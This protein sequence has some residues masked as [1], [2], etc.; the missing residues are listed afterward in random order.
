MITGKN[1]TGFWLLLM[2]SLSFAEGPKDTSRSSLPS[3]DM[4]PTGSVLTHVEIPRYDDQLRAKSLLEAEKLTVVSEDT[5]HGDIVKI[6]LLRPDGT[7][8][9]DADFVQADYKHT[10]GLLTSNDKTILR[11]DRFYATGQGVVTDWQNQQGLLLGPVTTQLI[12]NNPT[13]KMNPFSPPTRPSLLASLTGILLTAQLSAD[14]NEL[15]SE[16]RQNLQQ[17][18]R[19]QEAN[20]NQLHEEGNAIRHRQT[21]RDSASHNVLT[22]FLTKVGQISLLSQVKTTDGGQVVQQTA[23]KPKTA[24]SQKPHTTQIECDGGMFFDMETGI[25]CYLRNIEVTGLTKDNFTLNCTKELKVYLDSEKLKKASEKKDDSK[26]KET[27]KKKGSKKEELKKSLNDI[28]AIG[29][30]VLTGKDREGKDIE[31]HAAKAHY[32]AIKEEVILEGGNLSIQQ[33]NNIQRIKKPTPNA[34]IRID[35]SGNV[36]TSKHPFIGIY[37]TNQ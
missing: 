26:E 7:L 8:A 23:P 13:T 9:L 5:I 36:S 28:V 24:P 25:L 31:V 18:T 2:S 11:G 17:L 33:G 6:S 32:N 35:K 21:E 34:W 30:V 3:L 29:D 22:T 4:L 1:R 19:S 15:S 12:T 14:P 16:E 10:Q 37:Q 27:P 20:Y